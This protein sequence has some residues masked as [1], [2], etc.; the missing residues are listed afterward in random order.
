MFGSE[1]ESGRGV[2]KFYGRES[3]WLS[4]MPDGSSQQEEVQG[5]LT[6]SWASYVVGLGNI[7]DF[8]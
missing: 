2:I 1:S 6:R 5:G 8:H 3:G 7:F 4:C